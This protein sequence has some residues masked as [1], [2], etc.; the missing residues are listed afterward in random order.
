[1]MVERKPTAESRS[2]SRIVRD[3][4][5]FQVK[6]W[7][8]GMKD[9]ALVPLSLGAAVI[10]VLFYRKSRRGA[11]YGLMDL[12]HRFEDWV[13]LYGARP[14]AGAPADLDEYPDGYPFREGSSTETEPESPSGSA[15][16][17]SKER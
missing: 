6:L 7:L 2:R 15:S 14:S 5:V 17:R 11:L 1:M 3:V 8:E 12:G 10:D 13:D 16:S 4:L 9:I